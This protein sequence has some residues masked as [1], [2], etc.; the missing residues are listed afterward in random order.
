MENVGCND[1]K[2][3]VVVVNTVVNQ[4]LVF[5]NSRSLLGLDASTCKN[6]LSYYSVYLCSNFLVSIKT[7]GVYSYLLYKL[8]SLPNAYFK[9]SNNFCVN[10]ET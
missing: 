3:G 10:N 7:T 2:T 9:Q 4:F 5:Q 1:Y 8:Y 6:Y